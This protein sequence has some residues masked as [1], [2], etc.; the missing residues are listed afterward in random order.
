MGNE[1]KQIPEYAKGKWCQ[2]ENTGVIIVDKRQFGEEPQYKV[3]GYMVANIGMDETHIQDSITNR[4]YVID[5]VNT[6]VNQCQSVNKDNPLVVAE[7]I[8][9][10]V[11]ALKAANSDIETYWDKTKLLISANTY[12]LIK[13]VLNK[14]SEAN[15]MGTNEQE[16]NRLRKCYPLFTFDYKKEN[17]AKGFNNLTINYSEGSAFHTSIKDGRTDRELEQEL[18]HKHLQALMSQDLM[19]LYPDLYVHI[20]ADSNGCTVHVWVKRD[21]RDFESIGTLN[22][23][24]L[25]FHKTLTIWQKEALQ[26]KQDG[27]FFCSGHLKAERKSDY[28]YFYFAGNYCKQWGDEHPNHRDMAA[29]EDYI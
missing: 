23:L 13:E 4:K 18:D 11:T 24:D 5:L 7:T 27:W 3:K 12:E 29:R 1:T 22:V 8:K 28:G 10:M 19:K 21:G 9:E 14:I 16:V 6:S 2:A 25:D 20:Y 26:A 17:E 15:N